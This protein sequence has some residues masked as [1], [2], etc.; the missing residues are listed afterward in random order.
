MSIDQ[1]MLVQIKPG[2][3]VLWRVDGAGRCRSCDRWVVWCIT[4]GGKKMPV[5]EPAAPGMATVSHFSTC[6]DAGRWRN[7]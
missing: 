3:R 4:T 5:D 1:T 6:P 7:R 2:L